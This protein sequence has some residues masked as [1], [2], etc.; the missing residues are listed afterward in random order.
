[1]KWN[2]S[3]YWKLLSRYLKP[4]WQQVVLLGVLLLLNIGL[5]L[6]NPQI[7]RYFIDKVQAGEPL[8]I[9]LWAAGIYIG[10][11]LIQQLMAVG[12]TYVSQNLGWTST[13]A[14]RTDLVA[15]CLRL[16]MTFHKAQ[17]PGE[18]IERIDGDVSAL[19]N[20]FSNLLIEVVSH[21]ALMFGILVILFLEDWRIGIC[22]IFFVVFAMWVMRKIHGYAVPQYLTLREVVT[23]FYG[24][25][26]EVLGNTEDIRSNGAVAKIIR[27]FREILREWLPKQHRAVMA[28]RGLWTSTLAILGVGNALAFGVGGVL[29][30]KGIITVGAVFLIY[31]YIEILS[32]PLRQ[33]QTQLVH[34]QKAGASI[35]RV[36]ELFALQSKIVDGTGPGLTDGPLGVEMD[37][38]AFEYEEGVPV[39]QNLS[40]RLEPGKILGVLGRTGSGKTTMA[41]LMTRFYDVTQGEI[42][43]NGQPIQTIPLREVRRR[44][45]FVTQDVQLFNAS[46]R[47]NLTFFHQ[48][49]T[50]EMIWE[51]LRN[52]GLAEWVH[53]LPNGLDTML[54]SDGGG[55]SAGEAQLLAFVRVFLKNPSLIILDEASSRL[56]PLT[57]QLMEGA[58]HKLFEGRTGVII[59]HRLKTIER[60]DEIV[61]LEQGQVREMGQRAALANDPNSYFALL[62]KKGIE[63]VLV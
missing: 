59:A 27:R 50:D 39:L 1:M 58:L 44:I 56:D 3:G 2:R 62:L 63:E 4:Q 7:L 30:S 5:Q 48:E 20:F 31:S 13:N 52:I 46:V 41:R 26:G 47:D 19:F 57:E 22:M 9:L 36:E 38:V 14:L 60:A 25:L 8:R 49:I 45:A 18:I 15:H 24:F 53:S 34:L 29:W 35:Q 11:A 37:S 54:A 23:R 43:F 61:I 40:V 28:S 51:A 17:L 12:S 10:V 55:L 21:F 32:M 33:I 16:D 42:R 6:V